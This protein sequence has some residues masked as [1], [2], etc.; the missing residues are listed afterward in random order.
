MAR[1]VNNEHLRR[2]G[3]WLRF[4]RYVLY[5]QGSFVDYLCSFSIPLKQQYSEL[6]SSSLTCKR[7]DFSPSTLEQRCRKRRLGLSRC[8]FLWQVQ[9]VKLSRALYVH[10]LH[11]RRI[12][13]TS[14]MKRENETKTKQHASI[15]L[16]FFANWLK[17][18]PFLKK[19]IIVRIFAKIRYY[20]YPI[21]KKI[22]YIFHFLASEIQF[23]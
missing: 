22:L 20:I 2:I 21:Y 17:R 4:R 5:I 18:F 16:S 1:N 19:S 23:S 9:F 8:F 12:A 7:K 13:L 11:V 3:G 10:Y 15:Q 14:L 6:L